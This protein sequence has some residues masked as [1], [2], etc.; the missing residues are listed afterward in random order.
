MKEDYTVDPRPIAEMCHEALRIYCDSI[1]HPSY[2]HWL[3]ADPEVQESGVDGV[4]F[5]IRNPEA[6][7]AWLHANWVAHKERQGW[8]F[9]EVKDSDRK[10]HPCMVP[11][12]RLPVEHRRKDRIFQA[13]VRAMLEDV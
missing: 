5:L 2:P 3:Q 13:I 6:D 7:P 12:E 10:R 9:G 4:N 11:Y 1:G 8:T